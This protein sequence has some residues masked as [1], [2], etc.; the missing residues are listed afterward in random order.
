MT[1]AER[2]D[3]LC[4]TCVWFRPSVHEAFPRTEPEKRKG[5]R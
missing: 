3:M 2:E 5:K 4:R 1:D